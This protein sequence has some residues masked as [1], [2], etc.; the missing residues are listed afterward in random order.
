MSREHKVNALA[1]EQRSEFYRYTYV[2]VDNNNTEQFSSE[3]THLTSNRQK[4]FSK[5]G[6]NKLLSAPT[7]FTVFS[8]PGELKNI[9]DRSNSPCWQFVPNHSLFTNMMNQYKRLSKT[10]RKQVWPCISFY[11]PCFYTFFN[12][13]NQRTTAHNLSNWHIDQ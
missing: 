12:R 5:L 3:T 1:T 13:Q 11:I 10:T 6:H 9:W 2:K 7:T 4:H 8:L